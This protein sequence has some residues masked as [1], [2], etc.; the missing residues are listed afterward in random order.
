MNISAIDDFK[1]NIIV[2]N[3]I[4]AYASSDTTKFNGTFIMPFL[5]SNRF[6]VLDENKP[7]MIPV[8][9]TG[10][11]N[12]TVSLV[13]YSTDTAGRAQEQLN[14]ELFSCGFGFQFDA[15]EGV[16]V[17]DS[18]LTHRGITCNNSQEIVVPNGI[19]MG[20]FANNLEEIVVFE[21]IF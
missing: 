1:N 2:S 20:P 5:S 21:C 11:G 7:T 19:W 13:I 17:C 10:E 6:A 18:E 3:V 16:C 14:I 8:R 9:I 12:Q 4:A 15:V